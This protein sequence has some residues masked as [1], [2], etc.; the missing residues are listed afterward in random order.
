ML[1]ALR[2]TRFGAAIAATVV[3]LVCAAVLIIH[4]YLDPLE[5][6]QR[7]GTEQIGGL[8]W[9]LRDIRYEPDRY[10]LPPEGASALEQLQFGNY[11][12]DRIHSVIRTA[13]GVH[14]YFSHPPDLRTLDSEAECR[15]WLNDCGAVLQIQWDE[16]RKECA[17]VDKDLRSQK[18]NWRYVQ[19]ISHNAEGDLVVTDRSTNYSLVIA[20]MSIVDFAKWSDTA[21]KEWEQHRHP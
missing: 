2:R 20:D 3:A 11:W 16:V 10:L 14:E 8:L 21:V 7:E 9:S 6:Y 17:R 4:R 12:Y 18:L 15:A 19:C 5:R 1:N 13:D